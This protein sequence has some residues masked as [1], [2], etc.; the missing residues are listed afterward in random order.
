[1]G[2]IVDKGGDQLAVHQDLADILRSQPPITDVLIPVAAGSIT[3]GSYFGVMAG[4]VLGM[5]PPF[6]PVP[7]V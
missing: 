2:A 4:A 5:W 7:L 3:A 6:S 1:M